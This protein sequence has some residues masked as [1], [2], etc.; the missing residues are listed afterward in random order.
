MVL[1]T[2]DVSN[3]TSIPVQHITPSNFAPYGEVMSGE[4]QILQ[5]HIS[6]NYGTAIKM[7]NVTQSID[8]YNDCPSGEKSKPNWNIFRCSNPKHLIEIDG[9][10]SSY[11]AKVLE[12]HPFTTQTFVP[13]GQLSSKLSYIVIVAET[14]TTTT[15]NLPDPAS[16]RAFI[17]KGN[18][19]VTYG[20]GTW[21]APMVVIDDQVPFID[22][23]VFQ[24]ANG[25]PDEDCQECYFEPGYS[26]KYQVNIESKL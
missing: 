13:M 9:N 16:I 4:H 20:A 21:H 24:Y 11:L 2:F 6:A 19:A 8:N 22:F 26:I 10:T 12:R 18:Q 15:Q 3:V 5:D 7:L 1:A 23:A 25:V 17:V 14:D